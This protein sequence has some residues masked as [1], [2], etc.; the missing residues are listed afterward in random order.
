MKRYYVVRAI[1]DPPRSER[2]NLAQDAMDDARILAYHHPDQ[3]FGVFKLKY[4]VKGIE[5]K[6]PIVTVLTPASIS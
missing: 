5:A 4:T 3:V 1:A 2:I 6:P